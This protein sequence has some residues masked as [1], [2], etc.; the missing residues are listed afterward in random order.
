MDAQEYLKQVKQKSVMIEHKKEEQRE[1]EEYAT[2]V[3]RVNDGMPRSTDVSDRLSKA[4]AKLIDLQI[5]T[6]SMICDFSYMRADVIKHLEQLPETQYEVLYMRYIKGMKETDVA[7]K[8]NYCERHIRRI[9][10]Q[11]LKNLQRMLDSEIHTK[12]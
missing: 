7:E 12:H 6:A 9:G 8:M 10:K 4:V 11:G 3:S 2:C 5:E 1:L